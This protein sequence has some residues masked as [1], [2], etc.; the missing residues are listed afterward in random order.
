MIFYTQL[1]I[2]AQK[3]QDVSS[4]KVKIAW[5]IFSHFA[6]AP[7]NVYT[8][9]WEKQ[10]DAAADISVVLQILDQHFAT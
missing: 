1:S 9:W 5:T 8:N 10:D 2:A 7:V 6:T 3:K 4:K